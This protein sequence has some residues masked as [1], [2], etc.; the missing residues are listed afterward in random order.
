MAF[1]TNNCC[2]PLNPFKKWPEDTLGWSV[3]NSFYN[4]F[5]MPLL[6]PTSEGKQRRRY[7]SWNLK[8]DQSA[9]ILKS[10]LGLKF[11]VEVS[12]FSGAHR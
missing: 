5:V 9:P 11:D 1:V 8:L 7:L 6:F 4:H 12:Q 2:V 3:Q 10:T